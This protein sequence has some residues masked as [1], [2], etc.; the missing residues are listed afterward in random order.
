MTKDCFVDIA[1]DFCKPQPQQEF[2]IQNVRSI[3]KLGENK[4]AAQ[5]VARPTI[6]FTKEEQEP[7]NEFDLTDH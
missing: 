1:R 5:N 6:P 3:C 2:C 4:Y 7:V